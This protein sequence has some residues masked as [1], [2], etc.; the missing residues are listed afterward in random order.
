MIAVNGDIYCQPAIR[1]PLGPLPS[2]T[3]GAC[4]VSAHPRGL[5]QPARPG[6]EPRSRPPA[7]VARLRQS[8]TSAAVPPVMRGQLMSEIAPQLYHF[9][10]FGRSIRGNFLTYASRGHGLKPSGP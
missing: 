10:T 8:P 1:G 6:R 9:V 5:A 7:S 2:P 4:A 3:S